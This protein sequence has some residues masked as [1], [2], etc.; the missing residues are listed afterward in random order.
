[1]KTALVTGGTGFIGSHLV[2]HLLSKGYRVRCMI[3]QSSSLEWLKELEVEY[4]YGD[5]FTPEALRKAVENV[6]YVYHCAGV[7]AAKNRAGYFRGNQEGTR[8]ILEAC[9]ASAGGLK[10]FVYVSSQTAIGPGIGGEPVT[11][12]TPPHPITAYGESKLA[13]EKEVTSRMSW[14]PAVIVR[15][16]AVYGPRDVGILTFFQTISKGLEPLIGFGEKK[17]SLIH[18]SD[19]VRG[20]VMAGE[21]PKAAGTSYNLGSKRAYNWIELGVLASQIMNK[22]TI[23]IKIPHTLVLAIAGISGAVGNLGKKPP[24]FN[25]EK[26]KDITQANWT[27]SSEKAKVELGYEEQLTVEEAFKCTIEW[28]KQRGWI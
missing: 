1:M 18:S 20:I 8:N 9:M 25:F 13:A 16:P 17:V 21:N 10:K 11:E 27:M 2:E 12:S 14:I 5:L 28:Y 7:T 15:P 19:L 6:E 4:I 22:K 3:R 23:R 26:G 24:I